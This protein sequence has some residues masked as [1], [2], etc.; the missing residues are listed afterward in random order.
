MVCNVGRVFSL[1]FCISG[2]S[3]VVIVMS[4]CGM[5]WISLVLDIFGCDVIVMVV[6]FGVN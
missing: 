1:V 4:G 6:L 5:L 3:M 2:V